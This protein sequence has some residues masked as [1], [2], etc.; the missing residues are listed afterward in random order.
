MIYYIFGGMHTVAVDATHITMMLCKTRAV[1]TAIRAAV[2]SVSH[3][4]PPVMKS[5]T[6]D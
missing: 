6:V 5:S 4:S 2:C 3:M 1:R